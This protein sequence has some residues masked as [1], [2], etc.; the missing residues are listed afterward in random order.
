[1]ETF[2]LLKVDFFFPRNKSG[3][4]IFFFFFV[5]VGGGWGG[6]CKETHHSGSHSQ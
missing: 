5:G 3:E 4:G 1:M 2:Y 6:G